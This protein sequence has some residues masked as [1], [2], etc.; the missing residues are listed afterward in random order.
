MFL[1]AGGDYGPNHDRVEWRDEEL[2]RRQ[3]TYN[4]YKN[5]SSTQPALMHAP[6]PCRISRASPRIAET[7]QSLL[8]VLYDGNHRYG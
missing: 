3:K 1:V 8:L 5:I 7:H 4:L 6:E 2:W